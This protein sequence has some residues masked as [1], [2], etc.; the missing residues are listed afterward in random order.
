M[1]KTVQ[2]KIQQL[3]YTPGLAQRQVPLQSVQ[4]IELLVSMTWQKWEPNIGQSVE[5][6]WQGE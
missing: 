1:E 6:N 5:N 2:P 3:S 4:L